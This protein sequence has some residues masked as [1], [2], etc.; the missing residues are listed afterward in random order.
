MIKT[1]KLTASLAA[2]QAQSQAAFNG[3]LAHQQAAL[4]QAAG[5][6]TM[7]GQNSVAIGSNAVAGISALPPEPVP[8]GTPRCVGFIFD[9]EF[10]TKM[11]KAYNFIAAMVSAEHTK[12]VVTCVRTMA[13]ANEGETI[14]CTMSD[15]PTLP[16]TVMVAIVTFPLD[17]FGAIAVGNGWA[18]APLG[19]EQYTE[20]GM[21]YKSGA[22]LTFFTADEVGPPIT[23]QSNSRGTVPLSRAEF[24]RQQKEDKARDD[25]QDAMAKFPQSQAAK[26]PQSPPANGYSAMGTGTLSQMWRNLTGS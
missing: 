9:T 1:N 14:H 18:G 25:A 22:R 24:D 2:Q 5:G 4:R 23:Q 13:D 15:I 21:F 26:S 19:L 17:W 3:S 7:L 16:D 11:L 12:A 6:A 10:F 8:E 20:V